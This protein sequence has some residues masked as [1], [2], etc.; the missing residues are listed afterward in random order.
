M[1]SSG[2]TR[3]SASGPVDVSPAHKTI[4]CDN[5][6]SSYAQVSFFKTPPLLIRALGRP[7]RRQGH[8]EAA[9]RGRSGSGPSST[10]KSRGRPICR[11]KRAN[12]S[13][14]ARPVSTPSAVG[15]RR[16]THH[17]HHHWRFAPLDCIARK[18]GIPAGQVD[19]LLTAIGR[20]VQ[21]R[22]R[23]GL[24]DACLNTTR[25]FRLV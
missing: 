3:F 22:R 2:T 8:V 5:C 13:S 7:C 10:S 15:C 4:I 6:N 9:G 24:C 20:A 1:M 16:R 17:A 14:A 18:T 12:C 19:M 11:G 23:P 25:V 21:M